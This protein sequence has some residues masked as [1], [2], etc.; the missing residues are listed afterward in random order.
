V[1]DKCREIGEEVARWQQE[2]LWEGMG[3]LYRTEEIQDVD[4]PFLVALLKLV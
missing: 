1:F 3:S 2:K 4:C